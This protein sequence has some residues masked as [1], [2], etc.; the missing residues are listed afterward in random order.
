MLAQAACLAVGGSSHAPSNGG[1]QL[2]QAER[3]LPAS[4]AC[5]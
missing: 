4:C 2:G 1:M 3:W 5:Y